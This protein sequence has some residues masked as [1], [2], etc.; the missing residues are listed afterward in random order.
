MPN[1]IAQVKLF[2]WYTHAYDEKTTY[3]AFFFSHRLNTNSFILA[4]EGER[5]LYEGISNINSDPKIWDPI[6]GESIPPNMLQLIVKE[7]FSEG[8]GLR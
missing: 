6:K 8:R 3:Y 1:Q 5:W 7:V 2:K 4:H